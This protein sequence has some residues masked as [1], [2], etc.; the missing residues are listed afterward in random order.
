MKNKVYL[1]LVLLLIALTVSCSATPITGVDATVSNLAQTTV[2]T[3]TVLGN[4]Y[5]SETV[6]ARDENDSVADNFAPVDTNT[7][8]AETVRPDGWSDETHSKAADPN[9]AVVFP[10]D[11]V[12]TMTIT[13]APDDWQA[14]LNDMTATYGEPGSGSGPG[15]RQGGVGLDNPGLGSP[16]QGSPG[17][18][19]HSGWHRFRK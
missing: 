3:T 6:L 17:H 16:G 5:Q 19:S 1:F 7:A 15:G 9:Y 13:I 11:E 10:E 8:A 2:E 4:E 12:N 18:R 14:M